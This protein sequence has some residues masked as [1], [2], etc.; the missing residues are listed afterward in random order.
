MNAGDFFIR[1]TRPKLFELVLKDQETIL[2][3]IKR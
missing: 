2:N 1:T 3:S